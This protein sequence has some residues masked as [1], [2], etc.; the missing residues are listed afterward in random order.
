MG[1][2]NQKISAPGSAK[3]PNTGGHTDGVQK[4]SHG[5]GGALAKVKPAG[6]GDSGL[7]LP[8]QSPKANLAS[9][10][11]GQAVPDTS[12]AATKKPSRKGLAAFYGLS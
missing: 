11:I 9:M 4:G 12:A 8:V 2:L 10:K 3:M 5:R 6:A 7:R 1:K